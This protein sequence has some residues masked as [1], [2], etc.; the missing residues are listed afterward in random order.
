MFCPR[1]GSS[2]AEELKFCKACGANLSAVRKVVDTRE[3]GEKFGWSKPWAAEM[4][5]SGEEASRR[6][7][8]IRRHKEI[9][10]ATRRYQEI[11]AGVITGSTGV[12]LAV[13]LSVFM[14]GI[15]RSGNVST[16]AAEIISHLWVVGVIPLLIGIALIINGYFV[17]KKMVAQQNEKPEPDRLANEP[18]RQALR[19]AETGEIIPSTF[20]VTEGTTQHLGSSNR[21]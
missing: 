19:S 20:S 9:T 6:Q 2:Q 5:M 7:Q 15:I 13:F 18:Q 16:A 4:L 8:E 21:R 11:K 14:D 1:C 10:S 12:A 3:S 17:S